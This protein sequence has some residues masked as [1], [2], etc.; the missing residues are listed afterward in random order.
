MKNT[1]PIN[2]SPIIL[3]RYEISG[4]C[5]RVQLLLSLLDIPHEIIDLERDGSNQP[6]WFLEISP[7]AQVPVIDDNGLKLA[8]SNAIL[9][10]L[11]KKYSIENHWLPEDA[12][13]AAKIQRWLSIA[14][15]E[16]FSGPAIARF[17]TLFKADMNY[18][19]A[20][21]KSIKLLEMINNTLNNN[22]Y[23]TGDEINLSDISMYTYIK[24]APEGGIFLDG[25]SNIIPWLDR[26]ESQQGFIGM[27]SSL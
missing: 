14:A 25:Y 23:L 1:F 15:G 8:D 21:M 6:A 13:T 24:H 10:Y 20:K 7:M 9:V 2:S 18:T 26:I 4:H 22:N 3:Y 12:E 16:L 27:K 5:H 19:T 11:V 17:I